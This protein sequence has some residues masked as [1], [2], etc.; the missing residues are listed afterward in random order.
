MLLAVRLAVSLIVLSRISRRR[1][2]FTLIELLVVVAVVSVLAS[3]AIPQ[4]GLYKRK[5][6]D[7]SIESGLNSARVAMESAFEANDYTYIGITEAMLANSGYR[8]G[9]GFTLVI[10]SLAV[11]RYVLRGCQMGGNFPSF[12]YDSNLGS[13]VG[14]AGGC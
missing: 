1:A 10:E 5:S 11:D 8:G 4:Y 13:L 9:A 6:V 3:I 14:N 12:R 2:G 7:S